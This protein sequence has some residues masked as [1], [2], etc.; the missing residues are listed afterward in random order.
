MAL[1]VSIFGTNNTSASPAPSTLIPFIFAA[2][3]EIAPSKATGPKICA[4]NC[5]SATLAKSSLANMLE[6]I[7]GVGV[8]VA[9]NKAILGFSIAKACIK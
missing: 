9:D 5:S 6:G 7:A 3:G 2:A 4:P 1:P 8:S